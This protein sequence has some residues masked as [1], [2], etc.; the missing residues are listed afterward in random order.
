MKKHYALLPL[1]LA[2]IM[3]FTACGSGAGGTSPSQPSEPADTNAGADANA[4]GEGLTLTIMGKGS[5]LNKTYM[6]RIFARYEEATG[7]HIELVTVPDADFETEASRR[8]ANGEGT[9]IF[10]HFNNRDLDRFDVA[11]DFCYLNDEA[12][13]SDLTNSAKD[14]CQDE[15]GNLL[16]LPFWENSVSGCYYNKTILD[17]LGL[18]PA[19][20]QAEFNTLCQALAEVGY[21][22]LCW[23]ADGC[24][25]MMQFALD[26]VFA[27]DEELLDKLNAGKITYADIPQV[28]DMIQWVLDAAGR[29]WLGDDYLQTGWDQISPTMASGGAVMTFIWDTWFYTDMQTDGEYTKEDFALMPVFLNTDPEGTYEGGNLNMMMVNKTGPH[30]EQALEFL[31]F[32]AQPD[33]YNA[34]FE[35]IST[36][37]C[38]KGQT[39]NIQSAMVTDAQASIREHERVSTA[40][41][42]IAGYSGDDMNAAMERLFRRR[43]DVDGC[44]RLMDEMRLAAAAAAV[45]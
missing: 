20:T 43:V 18:K 22:P 45:K 9:D 31:R 29:G 15:D 32:C 25:W 27:D 39:T 6:Q 26:P 38:F 21:T 28:K 30:V 35:G 24:S 42:R 4:A 33:N 10:M 44:L 17:S 34:A 19:A 40:S 7:N 36:V 37:N 3:L 16:G 41:T 11:S 2:L 5:D 1:L 23:P 14:Y 8:F 13:V 12:W